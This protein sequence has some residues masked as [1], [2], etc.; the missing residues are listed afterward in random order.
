MLNHPA[1]NGFIQLISNLLPGTIGPS[2]GDWISTAFGE[3]GKGLITIFT[4]LQT[5]LA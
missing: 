5:M 3:G 2:L 1:N 4:K